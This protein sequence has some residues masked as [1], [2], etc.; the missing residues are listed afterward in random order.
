MVRNYKRKTERAK[1]TL[2][3]L[4]KA[5]QGIAEGLSV[6]KAA[7]IFKIPSSTLRIRLKSGTDSLPNLGRRCDFPPAHEK[8][9]A[10][11]V[12]TLSN[13][14]YGITKTKIRKIAF[15]YAEK[16]H[17]KHR[18]NK[19]TKLAGM[20][21]M[22]GFMT[23]NNINMR[24]RGERDVSHQGDIIDADNAICSNQEKEI[25]EPYKNT[26]IVIKIE[27]GLNDIIHQGNL[28]QEDYIGRYNPLKEN[29][30]VLNNLMVGVDEP[31]FYK[32]EDENQLNFKNTSI[33]IKTEPGITDCV[34]PDDI[35]QYNTTR[36]SMPGCSKSKEEHSNT[37]RFHCSVERFSDAEKTSETIAE[38]PENYQTKT[39]D[40]QQQTNDMPVAERWKMKWNDDR[41][42]G[43]FN[44]AGLKRSI[45]A[46]ERKRKGR[47]KQC[48]DAKFSRHKLENCSCGTHLKARDK[49]KAEVDALTQ[50]KEFLSAQISWIQAKPLQIKQG[51]TENDSDDDLS[52]ISTN[53]SS[54][55]CSRLKDVSFDSQT[56]INRD[57]EINNDSIVKNTFFGINGMLD[58]YQVFGEFVATELRNLKSDV[59]RRR[60]KRMIQKVIIEVSE[61]DEC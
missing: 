8:A 50:R 32:Q 2:D 38:R 47:E 4:K 40:Q 61:S 43:E 14:C 28:S 35:S 13:V 51:L 34:F 24:K 58:D 17:L 49:L 23:R 16:N 3:D 55:E 39:R 1:W 41:P 44:V 19:E 5:K 21:W 60:L 29:N 37:M 26:A 46:G 42:I 10:D 59:N 15:E 6:R 11:Y 25:D 45:T 36:G 20:D 52:T 7:Q 12:N 53:D 33:D 18:F 57:H 54:T 48:S 30:S 31:T 56:K 22:Y 27:P 9:L